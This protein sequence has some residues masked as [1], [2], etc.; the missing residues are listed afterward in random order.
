[1][2]LSSHMHSLLH[3]SMCIKQTTAVR[4][5][6]ASVTLAWEGAFT[7]S[8]NPKARGFI[9]HSPTNYKWSQT[10][11]CQVQYNALTFW[12]CKVFT[13]Q[14]QYSLSINTWFRFYCSIVMLKLRSLLGVHFHHSAVDEFFENIPRSDY[15]P[16]IW[17]TCQHC[18]Y[19]TFFLF[20]FTLF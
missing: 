3:S 16:D 12:R 6:L 20:Y 14:Q 11:G 5:F 18:F 19:P 7:A 17:R 1:M 2:A 9:K 10:H 4:W 8:E 15:I 13:G